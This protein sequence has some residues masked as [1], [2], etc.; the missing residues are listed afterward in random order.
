VHSPK[1][2]DTAAEVRRACFDA[3]ES[4]RDPRLHEKY[5][6]DICAMIGNVDSGKGTEMARFVDELRQ[7][8]PTENKGD[9]S[10]DDTVVEA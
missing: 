6:E 9:V 5:D 10:S 8:V 7:T 1:N 2:A 4:K 3:S